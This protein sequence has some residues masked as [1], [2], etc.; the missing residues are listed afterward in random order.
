MVIVEAHYDMA[1]L[2]CEDADDGALTLIPFV[3]LFASG[4]FQRL[5]VIF[6]KDFMDG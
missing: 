4:A 3:L 6:A 5:Y 1:W 2:S